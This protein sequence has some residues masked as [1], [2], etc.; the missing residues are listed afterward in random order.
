MRTAYATGHE[1]ATPSQRG[2][3]S[4]GAMASLMVFIFLLCFSR[5]LQDGQ[6]LYVDGEDSENSLRLYHTCNH[7]HEAWSSHLLSY[8]LSKG[9]NGK[10]TN[11]GRSKELAFKTIT[12]ARDVIRQMKSTV[13]L[14]QGGV[15]VFILQTTSYSF[16]DEPFSLTEEDSG[17]EESG[18][19]LVERCL[20]NKEMAISV[21]AYTI[22]KQTNDSTASWY[23]LFAGIWCAWA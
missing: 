12:H 10:D 6:R 15:I 7:N 16:I 11:N 18:I 1:P 5:S 14:P 2:W 20:T 22:F 17:T 21:N 3:Q 23:V 19:M 4:S 8:S 9:V 13:G